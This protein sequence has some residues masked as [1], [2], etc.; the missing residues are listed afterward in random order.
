M[1]ARSATTTGPVPALLGKSEA[2]ETLAARAGLAEFHTD[3]LKVADTIAALGRMLG[4]LSNPHVELRDS[5][6]IAGMNARLVF[7]KHERL[8]PEPLSVNGRHQSFEAGQASAYTPDF[9]VLELPDAYFCHFP[10]T[11]LA[12]SAGGDV[13]V[14]D[15]CSRFAGLVH[16]YET[17]LRQVLADAVRIDGTVV[18]LDDDVRPLNYCHW[19]VDWLPRLAFLGE[20]VHRPDTFVVVPPLGAEYQ[21][22][23]LALCGVPRERVVQLATMRG[24]RARRLLLPSDLREM[25][26]PGHGA[27]PWV[28]NYL[29]ATLGYGAFLGGL[30]G[31]PRRR[32]L[33]VSRDDAARRRVLNEAELLTALALLGYEP[34]SLA[35]LPV[36]RQIALFACA[37]HIVGLHGAGLANIVFAD[38]ATT[39]VEIF[40]ATYGMPSFY[41]LAAGMGMT[42]ASY[43]SDRVSAGERAQLDDI[44]VDVPDFLAKCR[45]LL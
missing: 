25:P 23:T 13:V 39:L 26:H 33:Y 8:L 42:Y 7:G 10:D 22:E 30:D 36:A 9:R 21:W 44:S 43:I 18:V 28:T 14:R 41:V 37:S 27:A 35:G 31:P 45:H 24:L 17:P 20:L 11:P 40:P 38:H 12:V 34:V 16:F 3:G 19:L 5:T 2:V 6:A 1:T 32:K 4:R 15:Y 29:R